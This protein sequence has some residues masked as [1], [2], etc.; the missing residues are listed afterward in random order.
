MSRRLC[1][2]P[3]F[4]GTC[5]RPILQ[6]SFPPDTL[7]CVLSSALTCSSSSMIRCSASFSSC[8]SSEFCLCAPSV[9]GWCSLSAAPSKSRNCCTWA[10]PSCTTSSHSPCTS[11]LVPSPG[12][13]P[14]LRCAR[15]STI[16]Q[17]ESLRAGVSGPRTNSD[18]GYGQ[19]STGFTSISIRSG[20]SNM[21][22]SKQRTC[23]W[24]G[25]VF[26]SGGRCR[27]QDGQRC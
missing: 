13:A 15:V 8:C 17:A 12:Q 16:R 9:V 18:S 1:S 11:S 25:S 21:S 4:C 2:P 26:P 22:G 20:H 3:L 6:T 5:S 23:C 24:S 7:A 10:H 27:R 19:C 14:C